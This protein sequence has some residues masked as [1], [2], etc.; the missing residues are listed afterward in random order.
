MIGRTIAI[1]KSSSLKSPLD[2]LISSFTTLYNL[3]H[4][5][6]QHNNHNSIDNIYN[7]NKAYPEYDFEMVL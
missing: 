5:P 2:M 7:S 3:F 4:E 6:Q 1:F